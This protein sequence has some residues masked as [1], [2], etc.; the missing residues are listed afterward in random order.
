MSDVT[1]W[2]W[3]KVKNKKIVLLFKHLMLLKHNLLLEPQMK[4]FISKLQCWL[5]LTEHY[6][7]GQV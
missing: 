5:T 1:N 4:S 6:L 2:F 3:L 7:C